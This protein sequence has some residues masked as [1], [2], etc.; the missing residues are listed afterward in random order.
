VEWYSPNLV[1]MDQTDRIVSLGVFSGFGSV[2]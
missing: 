2:D 1:D